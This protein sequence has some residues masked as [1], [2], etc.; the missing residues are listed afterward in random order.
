ML[1]TLGICGRLVGSLLWTGAV[2]AQNPEPPNYTIEVYTSEAAPGE[3]FFNTA[4]PPI[5]PVNI[6]ANDG[7]LLFSEHW[8]LKGF[9]WKVNRDGN[10][11]YY[12]R[13]LL[14]WVTR[15]PDL[16][17]LDTTYC[18]G[19][20]YADLHDF[21]RL[22]DGHKVLLAYEQVPYAMDTVVEG[23]DPDA[24]VVE[25][26][27]VQELDAQGDL[28][29]QWRAIEHLSP[30]DV[31]HQDLT[32]DE[33]SL[34]HGNAIDI[35]EDG[36][37]VVSSR[38]L[39]EITK[40][41]RNT[42]E[43]LWRWGGTQSDFTGVGGHPFTHQHSVRCLGNNRY[44]LFDN[45]NYSSEYTGLPAYSRAVEYALDLEEMVATE[46]WS[47]TH[48]E[49]LYGLAMGNVQRLPN[50]NTLINWGTLSQ[51]PEHGA[52]VTE[53]TPSGAVAFEMTFVPSENLYR[54]EKH[55]WLPTNG[56]V[57]CTDPF[58]CNFDPLASVNAGPADP[59]SLACVLP[60]AGYNCE[61]ACVQDGDEDAICDPVDNCPE[62]YNPDQTDTNNNNIGDACEQTSGLESPAGT[63][64]LAPVSYYL[65]TD[66]RRLDPDVSHRR[67]LLIAVHEDGTHRCVWFP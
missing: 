11:T 20:Y 22:P 30:G 49:M 51:H 40:I 58:A 33:I 43:V 38:V 24:W 65:T 41:D 31:P 18:V 12:D 17:I 16:Q 25:A 42:G 36:H 60:E 45:G 54:C 35:D 4:G 5:K 55:V 62:V 13:E 26:L 37:F 8:P 7:T 32:A 21:V 10:I 2:F 39:D 61:G 9:D 56:I 63:V 28:V 64:A 3:L 48:P 50:G 66:G 14:A 34:N 27:V 6:L 47:Y 52:V 44:L 57:G 23:G 19:G 1:R 15:T 53:V 46:V 29:F 59:D 67:G